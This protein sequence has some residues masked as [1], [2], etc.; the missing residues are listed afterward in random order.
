VVG[1][2]A[3]VARVV[4]EKLAVV[5]RVA[6]VRVA[7]PRVVAVRV[8]VPRVVA[9]WAVAERVVEVGVAAA[10]LAARAMEAKVTVVVVADQ[11]AVLR[12]LTASERA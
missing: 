3:V 11:L 2:M 4:E 1:V 12:S 7:V 6:A 5:V 8:A 10:A 9:V